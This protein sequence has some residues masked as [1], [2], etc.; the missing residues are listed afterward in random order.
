MP[1]GSIRAAARAMADMRAEWQLR[2]GPITARCFRP[3]SPLKSADRTDVSGGGRWHGTEK[4]RANPA[5]RRRYKANAQT[6]G[7]L[8]ENTLLTCGHSSRSFAAS[9]IEIETADRDSQLEAAALGL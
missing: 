7:V 4:R 2:F 8:L 1:S 3:G 6:L 9:S 5:R